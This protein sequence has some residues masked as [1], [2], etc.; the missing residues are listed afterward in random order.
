MKTNQNEIEMKSKP[1]SYQ[2]QSKSAILN[3][4]QIKF[5]IN[6]CCPKINPWNWMKIKL[7]PFWS[8]FTCYCLEIQF[9]SHFDE[10]S[11]K[12]SYFPTQKWDK[13]KNNGFG[14]GPQFLIIKSQHFEWKSMKI[15]WNS[16]PIWP[17]N[18]WKMT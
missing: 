15:E 9:K 5:E 16:S 10:N 12:I 14:L 1:I 11:E 18:Q 3:P 8:Q 2:N 7:N 17:E 6:Y 4:I 13:N